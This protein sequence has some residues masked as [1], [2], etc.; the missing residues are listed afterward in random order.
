V[1]RLLIIVLALGVGWGVILVQ[2]VR[3]PP[4]DAG[5]DWNAAELARGS[6]P[7][8]T[9]PLPNEWLAMEDPERYSQ[10]QRHF[11]GLDV[12]MAEIGYRYGELVAALEQGNW[13]YANYQTTKIGLTL[14]LSLERR[15]KRVKS[16]APFVSESIPALLAAIGS[17]DADR[18][19]QAIIQ[20]RN[21]CIQCHRS[22]NVL[23]M[24]TDFASF[25]S[26]ST[27]IADELNR[28]RELLTTESL[29]A[30]NLANG[31]RLFDEHC[32]DCHVLFPDESSPASNAAGPD[33]TGLQRHD[34]GY[35]I[36]ETV[37]P[38]GVVGLD[39]QSTMFQLSDGRTVVGRI[40]FEDAAS[41][42]LRTADDQLE[43]AKPDIDDSA[44][45]PRSI[46]PEGLLRQLSDGDTRDLF[47]YLQNDRQAPL[48]NQQNGR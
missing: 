24:G 8:P 36:K 33:L 46:M 25:Q 10:I 32:A 37:H 34:L 18:A 16:A 7:Q 2:A 9:V 19:G 35:L 3:R 47:G 42:K 48:P 11:R 28:Y 13:D 4:A 43:I 26:A 22:E 31:R 29:Q 30:A 17:R 40:E 23:Y 21:D 45:S 39:Y 27:E 5:A 14:E 6:Q 41:V 38:N 12:A 15:P 1:V 20:F 44:P